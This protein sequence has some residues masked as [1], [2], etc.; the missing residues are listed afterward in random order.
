MT[1]IPVLTFEVTPAPPE[2]GFLGDSLDIG[3]EFSCER[4]MSGWSFISLANDENH[5]HGYL[6]APRTMNRSAP[7]PTDVAH[8]SFE[9]LKSGNWSF[10]RRM[11]THY[12]HQLVDSEE[13]F[14]YK[15]RPLS[16]QLPPER[17][18]ALTRALSAVSRI[19]RGLSGDY[20]PPRTLE[21]LE[22]VLDT[23]YEVKWDGPQDPKNPVNWSLPR[24]IGILFLISM[25][26]LMVVFY[27]TSYLSGTRGM[28]KE[29]DIPHKTDV[30]LGL[31]TYQIGL[32]F[33]PLLLAPMSELFGRRPVYQISMG[34]FCILILPACFAK[35]LQTILV[36]RFFAAFVGSVSLSNS[37]GS[38]GDLFSEK[39][40]ALAFS[41][42]MIAPL[43]GP[44]IGPLLG[45]FIYE[46]LGWK[47]LNH[48]TL[49]F[50]TALVIVG[51]F[52]PETYGPVLMRK[53][54]A[55]LRKTKKDE[56]YMSRYCYKV[57]EGGILTLVKLNVKRPLLMLF[58][59]PICVFWALY[60]GVQYGIL[61]L[62]FTAYPIVFQEI[63]EWAP[64]VAGLSFLGLG[65]G[66]IIAVCMD[67]LNNKLISLHKPDT[68]TSLPI[69]ESKILIVCLA[70]I[71]S[72][73]SIF[74]FAWTC[75]PASIHPIW[76]I[77][78]GVPFGISNTL[79]F[80][81]GNAYLLSSY[82]LFA[83]SCLAGCTV[84]RSIL[85]GVLPLVAPK[86]YQDLGANMAMTVVG[87]LAAALA[88]I[89][90]GFYRWGKWVRAR[91]PILIN[92]QAE[93]EHRERLFAV[94][95]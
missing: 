61:Y 16:F 21:D 29:F 64:G 70:G 78:G 18:S 32:A 72:P 52:V 6:G 5:N 84:F 62:S 88:P 73:V 35:N 80:M 44:I 79:I 22:N 1:N 7:T 10:N 94:D 54:A 68:E 39:K 26:Y 40:K 57:G 46:G 49:I 60:I 17:A 11:G 87:I 15:L 8:L 75:S 14:E 24:K 23:D 95:G 42:F 9:Q 86:L 13:E 90:W 30:T 76:P 12:S 33:G 83:A 36:S 85:C 89:P 2:T 63:R 51:Y 53:K 37:P 71:L 66:I 25:Q 28:M 50:S 43:E 92:M 93:K 77:L 34:L 82:D 59:E 56:N 38:L 31:T 69:P 27:S 19:S 55:M 48:L 20:G 67:P 3:D 91:S 81:H 65:L 45:G 74:I 4:L 41:I 58:T 47:Y